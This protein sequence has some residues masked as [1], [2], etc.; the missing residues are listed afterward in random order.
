[1]RMCELCVQSTA[2]TIQ[3]AQYETQ[4][5]ICPHLDF[6]RPLSQRSRSYRRWGDP[7]GWRSAGVVLERERVVIESR[8]PS[9][10]H[11]H[12]CTDCQSCNCCVLWVKQVWLDQGPFRSERSV[13]SL[14][15]KLILKMIFM[16]REMLSR[17]WERNS[18]GLTSSKNNLLISAQSYNTTATKNIHSLREWIKP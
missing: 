18:F 13:C 12:S 6:H 8:P 1:M 5:K 9:L 17:P 4:L 11:I 16:T 14:Q 3:L 10:L 2:R 7:F 15:K